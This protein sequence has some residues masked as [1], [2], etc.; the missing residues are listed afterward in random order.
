MDG[1]AAIEVL[2]QNLINTLKD[3]YSLIRGLDGA[4]QQLQRTLDMIQA[5][6]NDAENKSITEKAV[7]AWLRELEVVAFNADNVLDELSYQLLH[8][9]VEKMKTPNPSPKAKDM[10]LSCFSS[11]K[12]ISRRH[13]MAH[14]IKNINAEFESMNKRATGLG[15][16]SILLNAPVAAHTPIETNSI[17]CDPIFFGRDDDVSEVVDVLTHIPQD[18]IISIV[19]LVG[20]GGMGKTTLTRNVFNHER[21]KTFGSHI[22]VH[23][24][25]TFDP[26]SLYNKIHSTLAST[27]GDRVERVEHEEAILNKLREVLRSKTYLLVLDDV[28]NEDIL[29]WE[30]FINNMKG[31]SS[32][33]G[34]G[35]IITTRM[36]NVA[37]IVDPFYIHQV[38]GLSDEQCWSIIKAR[39]FDENVEVPSG[40]ETIGKEIAKRCQGLPLAANVVGG[41]LRRC[42]SVQDWRS[43]KENWL[44]D[45]EGGENISKILKLSYDHLSLPSLKKCF[46]FCSIFPKGLKIKKDELIE[47]W[48]AEGF[49]QPSRRDDMES[50][51][52][53]FFNVLL[54][55]SL[56]QIA[57]EDYRGREWCLM[58]DLV[59]DLA[60]SVLS[61]NA[62]G[63]TLVRY[64]FHEKELSRIPEEVSRNLRTLLLGDGTSIFSDFKCLHNLT[65]YGHEFK[66]LSISIKELI[67]L[68]NLNISHTSIHNIPEWIG[69]LHHLQT[70]R[71]EIIGL[72][73]L[74][75]T[76]KYLINLR[77]LHIRSDTKL[78]AE[79]GKLTSLQ[80]IGY[81]S[82]GKEKSYQ[83]EELGSLKNLK[84][85]LEIR[86]LERVRDKEE[87]MKANMLQKLNLSELVFEWGERDSSADRNDENVLEGLQPH[88]NLKVLRIEG[89]KG[90][91]FPIWCKKMAVRDGPRGSWVPLDNLIEISLWNCS[92]CEEIPMLDHSLPNLK[93]LSLI[94]LKKVR[95]IKFSFKNLKSLEIY[96]LERLQ[97]LP[98]SF[99]Y[100]NQSLSNLEIEKCPVLSELPDGLDTLNSLEE[101]TIRDCPNLKWIETPSRG[102]K[103]YQGILR[104][105]RIEGCEKLV[106]FPRQVLE[107]SAPTIE[108][109]VLKGLKSLKNL[110]MLIDCLAKSSPCLEELTIRG[111]PNF[112]ASGFIE[113]WDLGRLKKLKID[114]SLEWSRENSVGIGETVEGML[115]GCGNS[116]FYFSLKGVEN[117]EWMPQS[118]QHLTALSSL[119]LE[120]IG[121]QELPQW[122][123]NFSNMYDL[124]LVGCKKL[125]CLPS[126]DALKHLTDFRRLQIIDCPELCIDSEWRN[127]PNLDIIDGFDIGRLC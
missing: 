74:P 102:A 10:V 17:T 45:G 54:Q 88:A 35:I 44:S 125:K 93:S 26:I 118:F 42:K 34:N 73:K 61:N 23:V 49:L 92:E 71:A 37:S 18:Q 76:L 122:L 90:K 111:V 120:N 107:S 14:T 117:W 3:E 100:N 33:K 39:S 41:V 78:P 63:S 72:L 104:K 103:K 8:K 62:D 57:E 94:N 53:M 98:E 27:N 36:A 96:G 66:E 75:S 55:N 83:I 67:H 82:V 20:M 79:I 50:V 6:L 86:N 113:S 91:T 108:T 11:C 110:P 97:C 5:Y 19:A 112:M 124:T 85:S 77:H 116:L 21:L 68:R 119:M 60:S 4:A 38:K 2:V 114:V 47:L 101:L 58:H 81:F 80:T 46:A 70:F 69:E 48:M 51:G 56:L 89:Y 123:G 22:W 24:S 126:V 30:G 12:S 115:Q 43:I 29:K 31:V 1:G 16:Q 87:A 13:N 28:W 84:G 99:F 64:M 127:H 105:L 95:S 52:N 15:L 7:Q 59:H 106:E 25:Q 32:T 65:L 40:F 9:K 109:L 121:V